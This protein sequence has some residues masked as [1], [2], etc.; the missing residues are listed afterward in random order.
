MELTRI[1]RE[2]NNQTI[3]LPED[4]RFDSDEV[5]I[6]RVGNSVVLTPKI[7]STDE[8]AMA[9]IQA[10]IGENRGWASEKDMIKDMAEFRRNYDETEYIFSHPATAREILDGLAESWDDCIPESEALA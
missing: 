7:L 2:G 1:F 3:R 9:K 8:M 10:L 4:C 6:G 5:F